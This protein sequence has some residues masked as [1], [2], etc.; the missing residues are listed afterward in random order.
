MEQ[1]IKDMEQPNKDDEQVRSAQ[2]VYRSVEEKFEAV[3]DDVNLLKAEIQQTL[4]NLREFVMKERAIS[5]QS[6]FRALGPH[7]SNGGRADG[8]D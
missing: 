4:V 2:V 6:V 1:P 5:P 7:P 3:Q 8:G